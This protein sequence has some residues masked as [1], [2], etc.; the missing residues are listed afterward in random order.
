MEVRKFKTKQ[1]IQW[2]NCGWRLARK[3]YMTWFSTALLLTAVTLV[4]SYI[5]VIGP[6]VTLFLF[7]IIL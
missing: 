7:P 5:P 4:L 3:R 1:T 6:V 2:I